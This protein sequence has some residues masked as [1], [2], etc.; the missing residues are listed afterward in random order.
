MVQRDII[1][2][3]IEQAGKLIAKIM[4]DFLGLKSLGQT[5]VGVEQATQELKEKLDF[6]LVIFL[7]QTP[8]EMQAYFDGKHFSTASMEELLSYLTEVAHFK[9]PTEREEAVLL[10]EKILDFY[11]IVNASSEVF[12]MERMRGEAEVRKVLD[13]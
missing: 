13:I 6:D 10:F 1:K 7:K 9:L 2:D 5:D 11:K 4:V 3:Q 12:S 8:E